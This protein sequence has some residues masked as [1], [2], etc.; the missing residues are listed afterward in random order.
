MNNLYITELGQLLAS[1]IEPVESIIGTAMPLEARQ[2]II[3]TGFFR[4]IEDEIIGAWFAR[5]VS[6]RTEL[7]EII[8][9]VDVLAPIPLS[10]I[11]TN[12]H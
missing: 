12:L 4:P 11:S 3:E 6:V 2:K 9:R 5:F 10:S 1:L 7:L 8:R